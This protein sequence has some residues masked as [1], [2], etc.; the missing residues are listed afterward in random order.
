VIRHLYTAALGALV[1]GYAPVAVSRRLA[2]GVPINL[3]ARL[4]YAAAPAPRRPVG[5]VH[6]VSVGEALAARPLLE[7]LRERHP[8]LSLVVSTVTETGAR[9]VRERFQGIA[10]HRYFPLD[11]PGAVRRT[12]NAIGPAFLVCMETE[13]WPNLLRALRTRGIPVMIANGRLS[14]RSFR[15]YRRVRRF[16]RP[17]LGGVAV[18]AMQSSEDARR[19]IA[20][21][22]PADRV[23]V[24]GNVKHDALPD[25]TGAAELW[26][27]LLG[28]ERG[29]PAWVAGST[30]RGEEEAV[31]EA[32]R[33]AAREERDLA[34]VIAPRHPER[35]PEVIALIQ[36]RGW[37]AT[38]RSELPAARRRGAVVVLDTVGE[39]ARLYAVADV[40]FVGGSL[41]PAGGH[42]M[43]EAALQRKP[44]LFG[45]YTSNFREA[46][47]LL[48]A[49]GSG[50]V[51][52]DAAEL[53]QALRSLLLDPVLR[54]TLGDAG[55]EAAAS[56]HG[57]VRETLDLLDRFVY[58]APAAP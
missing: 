17:M 22:A 23:V 3:R 25:T 7:G 49:C 33:I 31:L 28:L 43:L 8:E 55:Y 19:I 13:L 39:L 32:H 45:P 27:S 4:G 51:V 5:W 41:V 34:L 15:R 2:R 12:V 20:V 42:N 30:H 9:I 48:S 14:D 1:A 6:A 26:R 24:T 38:R 50:R 11:F 35:V 18:F 40:V 53:T 37:S 56:R 54:Q 10:E 46:A 52:K 44:T 16:L 47:A 21:G 36:A 58:P 57:A 29:Q